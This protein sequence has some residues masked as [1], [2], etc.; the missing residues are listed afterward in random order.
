MR[1]R[2]HRYGRSHFRGVWN[3]AVALVLLAGLLS[4]DGDPP[5]TA[6]DEPLNVIVI[7]ADDLGYE[8]IGANGGES[9]RT[10]EID[11]MA[12]GG[13]RFQHCYSQPLCT[14]SRVKI[15][16]G[17]SNVRNYVRF[18]LL[19]TSQT[20]FGHL[21]RNAG[22][23]T[24]IIGKWQLGDDPQSPRDAG[25]DRHCLWQVGGGR[26][27]STG[28]DNR[29]AQPF[30]QVDGN[31]KTFADTDYGPRIV[32]DYG[33]DFIEESH[34]AGK[35]F[36]L[37]YPMILTHCPFSPTP[38]SP[39]WMVDDSTILTYKGQAHYF[40]DMVA[41]MDRIVGK[42]NGKLEE[43][44]IAENTLIVFTGDNG[45][46][47]P[48]VSTMYGREVAGAKGEATDGGTRVPL[49]V[50]WP[51][52]VEPNST[53]TD[54]VDFSDM[55]PTICEAAGIEVPD[56]LDIDGRSF[57]P[58]LLGETADPREWV[59][60]WY[61]RNGEAS[62]ARVFARTQRY[63]LYQSGEF[64]EVPVD[65]EENSPLQYETLDEEAKA[66]Y[67]MLREALDHY[68]ERRLEDI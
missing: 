14:P 61:S 8:T 56:S 48:I 2:F 23:S 29:Y 15:M 1:T 42:I 62:E 32:S 6:I 50:S 55:L 58:R 68:R 41:E 13:M 30:L 31:R 54:L 17:I 66:T 33:L 7:M 46:D 64:Y 39:E 11:R 45:T 38:E 12:A 63:K 49:I 25:F 47:R 4:C 10:P 3:A 21:F 65:Y 18:G 27:D 52:V 9:Y 20:T 51:G 60:N 26:M 22:Y 67:E 59:Y 36:L 43:M 37:Y 34:A 40:G 16:T 57:L 35:P 5:A 19:D 24:G 28:R 53:T 44:G